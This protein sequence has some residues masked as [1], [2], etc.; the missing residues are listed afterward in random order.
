MALSPTALDTGAFCPHGDFA[1][2]GAALGPLK[3]L[4]FVV[5]DI[6]DIAGRVTG[7]GNPDWLAT[8]AP[9]PRHAAAVQ[10]L[11]DAGA[12]I[13]GKTIT[14]ELAFSLNGQN[15]HYGTPRNA[16]TPDRIPGGSS[17]GSASAVGHGIVDFALGSDTGGSVRIP[18]ALNGIFGIRPTHGAVDIA[19]V[20]PLARSFDTVGWF[21][22]RA[23]VLRRVGDVLLPPDRPGIALTRF[24]PVGDAFA[25]A[26]APVAACVHA[27]LA[28]ARVALPLAPEI[29]LTASLGG[30]AEW[31]R[32]FRRL[33]PREIWAEHR[34]WIETSHPRFGPEIAE[35]FALSRAVAATPPGDDLD[36]RAKAAA[37]LD[38]VLGHD[39][40]L[41]IPTAAT[42]APKLDMSAEELAHFRDRTLS[43]TSIAGLGRLPQVQI[44]AGLVDGA[45]V[46]L[47]LIGPRG[48][49]RALLALA[50]RV[51]AALA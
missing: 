9:A 25:L 18:A 29:D 19:G 48:S 17:C 22:C 5:K 43:L 35:R 49:D 12:D 14:D 38:G 6:F 1:I 4:R 15:F 8:H 31:L 51:A 27:A 26:D 7:C 30:F 16:V 24:M 37:H 28:R 34:A 36:F 39:G 32:R 10:A 21:A 33:Q 13:L 47:S 40:V 20:M 41:I 46:G 44:P 45:A 42:I 2:A 50:E 23:D 3:G 11:L